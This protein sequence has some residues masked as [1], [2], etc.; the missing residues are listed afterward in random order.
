M[1]RYL[2]STLVSMLTLNLCFSQAFASPTD[3]V[4]SYRVKDIIEKD[5]YRQGTL[6]K[7]YTDPE[8]QLQDAD[9]RCGQQLL[10]YRSRDLGQAAFFLKPE[11]AEDR[12]YNFSVFRGA[13]FSQNRKCQMSIANKDLPTLFQSQVCRAFFAAKES[14]GGMSR[15]LFFPNM[16]P[17]PGQDFSASDEA[18][19]RAMVMGMVTGLPLGIATAYLVEVPVTAGAPPEIRINEVTTGFVFFVKT[20]LKN[21]IV[22]E[23]IR[24]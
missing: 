13:L 16:E 23:P 22:L 3:F 20:V 18:L 6:C 15:Y 17:I 24:E 14:S 5:G 12:L 1:A 19:A 9:S 8:G 4:G 7:P 10:F 21:M 2:F 11:G